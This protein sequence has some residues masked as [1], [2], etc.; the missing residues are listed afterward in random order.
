MAKKANAI[1]QNAVGMGF[2]QID[3][4]GILQY[5]KEYGKSK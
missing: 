5:L 4:T 1:Y 3:Y 2:G